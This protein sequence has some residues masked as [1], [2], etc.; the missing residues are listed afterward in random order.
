[1][2]DKIYLKNSVKEYHSSDEVITEL[3]EYGLLYE[4]QEWEGL[5]REPKTKGYI[6]YYTQL[7]RL[8]NKEEEHLMNDINI[9]KM[10]TIN[11]V[12]DF[13]NLSRPTI[14]KLLSTGNLPYIELFGQKRIQVL[15]VL[16]YIQNNIR[17]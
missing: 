5:G 6:L 17:K 13:L 14:Y 11:Q 12:C 9:Y 8:L 15:E 7:M 4:I 2:H 16:K 10:L 1:M 3:K